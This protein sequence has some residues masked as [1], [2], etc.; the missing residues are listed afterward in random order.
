M[1]PLN[2]GFDMVDQQLTRADSRHSTEFEIAPGV[3]EFNIPM[4]TFLSDKAH[5]DA[6]AVGALV[7]HDSRVLLVQRSATDSSPLKWETPGGACDEEDRTILHAT[8]RELWE[9]AGLSAVKM[10]RCVDHWDWVS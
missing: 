3:I 1:N 8:S 10:V 4:K 2:P 5:W 7:Y 9:E 6:L